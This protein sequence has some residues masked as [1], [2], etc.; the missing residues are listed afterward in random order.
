VAGRRSDDRAA[1]AARRAERRQAPGDQR[2]SGELDERLRA[3]GPEPFPGAGGR[4]QRG[5]IESLLIRP[6][7]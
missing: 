7:S 5:R 6:A 3:A 4:D 2:P 1:D